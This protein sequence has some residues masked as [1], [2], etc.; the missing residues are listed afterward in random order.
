MHSGFEHPSWCPISAA[1]KPS[2]GRQASRMRRPG[3]VL[4]R[5]SPSRY[6]GSAPFGTVELYRGGPGGLSERETAIALLIVDDLVRVVLDD[7]TGHDYRR[8]PG[9]SHPIPLFGRAE[10]PQA[11]A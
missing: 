10:I 9:S 4:L 11:T 6:I 5:R 8:T 2:Q 1:P 7:I 3:P